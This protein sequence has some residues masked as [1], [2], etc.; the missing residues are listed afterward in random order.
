MLS[1]IRSPEELESWTSRADHPL[2]ATVFA[3]WH[4]DP[5]VEGFVLVDD[6]PVGYG[7]VWADPQENEAELARIVV[8][9]EARRRGLGRALV[10][11]LV[12]EARGLGFQE[13]WL[14]VVPTNAAALACYRSAG[15]QRATPEEEERFNRG[16]P[17][18]YAWM[19]LGEED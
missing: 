10:T 4:A 15:F 2:P 8:A 19:T 5:D 12:E 17:R 1:W 9:P 13:I 11:M 6:E 3:E 7:E 18:A 14:R 16:Q